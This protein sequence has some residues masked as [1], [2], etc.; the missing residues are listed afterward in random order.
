MY[1]LMALLDVNGN[2]FV[3]CIR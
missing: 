3:R 1:T 2:G